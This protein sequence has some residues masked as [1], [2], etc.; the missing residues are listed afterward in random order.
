MDDQ[1]NTSSNTLTIKPYESSEALGKLFTALSKAQAEMKP[2]VLDMVNPHYKSKYAS[3]TSCQDAY[4]G[5]LSKHGLS[6]VQ[7]VFSIGNAYYC[8]SMLGHS[9][10]GEW[11]ANTFRLLINRQD[12]QGLGSAITYARRYGA[13]SLVGV[14]DTEDDDGNASLPEKKP[15][16]PPA[17]PKNYA[18]GAD[19]DFDQFMDQAPPDEPPFTLL[20]ELRSLVETKGIAHDKVPGMI[21]MATGKSVRSTELSDEELRAV[22]KFIQLK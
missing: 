9:E 16:S 15:H 14:V 7:Q 6:I 4:R 11:I 20:D 18:P 22:I 21:K 12:M 2:A 8:R 10:S 3:L 1:S 19:N 17:K 13:N 5:P